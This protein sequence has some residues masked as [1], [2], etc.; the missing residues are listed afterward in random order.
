MLLCNQQAD[1]QCTIYFQFRGALGS[2]LLFHI[3]QISLTHSTAYHTLLSVH[4]SISKERCSHL[5]NSINLKAMFLLR[6]KKIMKSSPWMEVVNKNY[7][8]C[9]NI[10]VIWTF[11]FYFIQSTYPSFFSLMKGS[12]IHTYEKNKEKRLCLN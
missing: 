7:D 2:K 8:Q 1:V 9:G 12:K 10:K 3:L 5:R 4:D 11:K 6:R